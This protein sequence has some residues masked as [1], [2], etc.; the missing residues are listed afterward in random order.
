MSKIEFRLEGRPIPY[1][2]P[3]FRSKWNPK[4]AGSPGATRQL[5]DLALLVRK[6][7]REQ[8]PDWDPARPVKMSARF[9]FSPSKAD[10]GRGRL[11]GFVD[12]IVEQV[13]NGYW[14]MVP[15]VDNLS[16]LI[17]ESLQHGGA[18]ENDQQVVILV[19]RKERDPR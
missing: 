8:A 9:G 13:E 16:K 4:G 17:M 10:G 19:A 18:V 15:D 12:V 11:H 5:A 3:A 14:I 2:R 1:S 6:A 7:I